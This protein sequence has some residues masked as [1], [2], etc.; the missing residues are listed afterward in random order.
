MATCTFAVGTADTGA[1]PNTSGAF[2]PAVDDLLVAFIVASGT[3]QATATLTSSLGGG[4]TFTQFAKA[5]Y[6]A[7][8]NSV[9]GFVANQL[10]SSATSQTVTFDTAADG[11]T[12]TVIF[13][14]RVSGMSRVGLNAIRQSAVQ[15]NASASTQVIIGLGAVCLTG[16]PTLI[17][18][19]NST[20][21]AGI[22][23]QT[24]WTEPASGDL[25]YS[26]PTTGG[27]VCH[28][29]SGFTGGTLSSSTNSASV[30]GGIAAEL[31]TSAAPAP[32]TRTLSALG[33]G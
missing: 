14:Y 8:A 23:P 13:V 22:A 15:D 25:G 3:T 24:G 9:Y 32:T 29:D 31:D 10:V 16:N 19:G 2:T 6:S 21:P 18:V 20:S 30:W 12:G 28:R 1:T 17:G 5:A 7:S 26:T 33:V 4:F 11:A 27:W